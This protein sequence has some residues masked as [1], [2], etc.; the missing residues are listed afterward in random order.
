MS[1]ARM[2]KVECFRFDPESDTAPYWQ[3][4]EVPLDGQMSVHDCLLYIRE[5]L[6]PGL[7]FFI[8]CKRGVC[9]RCNM[10]INDKAGLACVV[11]VSGDIRVAPVKTEGVIRDLWIESL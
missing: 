7:A 10:R 11:E 9:G 4:Y 1:D 2:V 5:N 3:T 6:D 8:N